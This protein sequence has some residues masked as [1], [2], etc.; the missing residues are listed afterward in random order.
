M[1]LL[2]FGFGSANYALSGDAI[3]ALPAGIDSVSLEPLIDEEFGSDVEFR[4][5]VSAVIGAEAYTMYES[6][7]VKAAVE[8]AILGFVA[9][10]AISLGPVM[11]VLF[12]ELFPNQLRGL[13]ISFA[14]LI[15]SGVSFG[16][17]LLFPWELEN[18][19]FSWC[20]AS[21]RRR[22]AGRLKNSRMIL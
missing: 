19:D 9:S 12:S 14:G 21:C 13:A 22:K 3:A 1:F 6:Q 11:W 7:L 17:Q 15:N 5:A 16:V 18:L 4:Q 8:L 10:F 20:C 2:S